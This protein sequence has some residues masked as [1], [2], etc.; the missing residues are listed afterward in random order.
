M[1]GNLG[2]IVGDG[3]PGSDR[4]VSRSNL[5]AVQPPSPF[6]CGIF[7]TLRYKASADPTREDA[8]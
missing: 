1:I 5:A 7:A 4:Q 6:P 8:R 3:D 2:P